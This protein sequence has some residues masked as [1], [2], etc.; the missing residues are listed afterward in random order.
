MNFNTIENDSEMYQKLGKSFWY[1]I[2]TLPLDAWSVI[3]STCSS[4]AGLVAPLRC[5]FARS[6]FRP[7]HLGIHFIFQIDVPPSICR[8]VLSLSPLF[9]SNRNRSD[10][11]NRNDENREG[12]KRQQNRSHC[13]SLPFHVVSTAADGCCCCARMTIEGNS[14]S[15][16]FCVSP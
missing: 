15:S 3:A 11:L 16:L 5:P 14:F 10:C 2:Q 8:I 7:F 1:L 4:S 9:P 6:F 12:I 13:R